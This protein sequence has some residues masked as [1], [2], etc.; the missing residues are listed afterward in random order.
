[1]FDDPSLL[2]WTMFWT[3]LTLAALLPRHHFDDAFNWAGRLILHGFVGLIGPVQDVSR[4][5]KLRP[6]DG[7]RTLRSAIALL[8]LPIG[9]SALFIAL[10]AQANP[11]IESVFAR[12]ELPGFWRGISHLLFWMIALLLVWPSLRP[13]RLATLH[14]AGL[15][16][17]RVL[18]DVRLT[19]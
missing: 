17:E 12:L 3:A 6:T 7:R 5:L 10:F 14:L 8:L 16:T 13:N 18:P 4:L 2:G 15:D 9:G 19:S 1:M 11:L